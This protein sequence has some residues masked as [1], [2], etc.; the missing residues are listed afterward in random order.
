MRSVA[1]PIDAAIPLDLSHFH[2]TYLTVRLPTIFDIVDLDLS[3][4]LAFVIHG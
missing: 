3:F 2:L 4:L 1:I